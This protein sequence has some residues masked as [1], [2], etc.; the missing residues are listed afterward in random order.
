[1]ARQALAASGFAGSA[2][3]LRRAQ[4]AQ[5]WVAAS[6]TREACTRR[7]LQGFQAAGGTLDARV[8]ELAA[9][10]AYNPQRSHHQLPPYSEAE[11]ERLASCLLRR[12]PS[13]SY[14]ARTRQALA[15][16]ARGSPIPWRARHWSRGQPRAGCS[17]GP[18]RP[19]SSRSR[20]TWAARTMW[21]ASGAGS[22]KPA[23]T[24]SRPWTW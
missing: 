1:M 15:A 12:P 16:A 17:P 13:T 5:Y 18:A 20:S 8:A 22:W 7:M 19:A 23:G 21:S 2:A 11:W 24:C 10:R 4:V 6:G 14:T 3:D 9:G